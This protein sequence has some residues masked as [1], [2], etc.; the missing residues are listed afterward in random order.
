MIRTM[1]NESEKLP[2]EY[3]LK[4]S[5]RIYAR[6]LVVFFGVVLL[7]CILFRSV[8]L[9]TRFPIAARWVIIMIAGGAGGVLNAV[10]SREALIAPH[11]I[12][13]PA[14]GLALELGFLGNAV[15]GMSA[16][17]VVWA[18]Q[19]SSMDPIRSV[20]AAVLSGF[21]GSRIL[22]A[23]LERRTLASARGALLTDID[24]LM[25]KLEELRKEAEEPKDVKLQE[26]EIGLLEL[27][28]RF[29]KASRGGYDV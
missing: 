20:A 12:R 13:L 23:E 9:T 10:L 26:L 8:L 15:F 16:A 18:T 29:E 3:P 2:L 21:G 25:D 5:L 1:N 27:T 17:F 7:D 24:I 28:E 19:L 11:R 6:R 14:G 22:V 4:E